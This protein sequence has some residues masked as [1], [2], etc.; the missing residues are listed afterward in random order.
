MLK[1]YSCP[2][3]L[4]LQF[5]EMMVTAFELS[6][7][8]FAVGYFL[9]D[10]SIHYA[11]PAFDRFLNIL[12]IILSGL[13]VSIFLFTKEAFQNKILFNHSRPDLLSYSDYMSF[14]INKYAKTFFSEN[15][16]TAL[17]RDI[18]TIANYVDASRKKIGDVHES[19]G[20]KRKFS[21]QPT[22]QKYIKEKID[23]HFLEDNDI[24]PEP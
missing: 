16:S 23:E 13:Y 8:F 4:S 15:P 7:L 19:V 18:D 12:G 10:T 11:A 17:F 20:F 22:F 14:K 3:D 2:V 21:Y 1:R 24:P 6:V 5:T 9:W